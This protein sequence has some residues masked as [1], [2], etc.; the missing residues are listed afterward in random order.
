MTINT[1]VNLIEIVSSNVTANDT[2]QTLIVTANPKTIKT[3]VQLDCDA[4]NV[5]VFVKESND[6]ALEGEM[7]IKDFDSNQNLYVPRLVIED[8]LTHDLYAI[9][10]PSSTATTE[11]LH[12]VEYRG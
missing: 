3:V 5:C 8:I 7:L 4:V 2:T 12:I 9:L 10:D 1:N 11:M 6:T